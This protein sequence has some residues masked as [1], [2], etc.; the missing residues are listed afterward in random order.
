MGTQPARPTT[1]QEEGHNNMIRPILGVLTGFAVTVGLSVFNRAGR[2]KVTLHEPSYHLRNQ[3]KDTR[4]EKQGMSDALEGLAPQL[5]RSVSYMRGWYK[6]AEEVFAAC[7]NEAGE[8]ESKQAYDEGYGDGYHG[9][10]QTQTGTDYTTG[11]TD[12]ARSR[13]LHNDPEYKRGLED[14]ELNVVAEGDQ[15][16]K[17]RLGHCA[18][19]AAKVFEPA[20][21]QTTPQQSPLYGP[22]TDNYYYQIG[23]THGSRG[24]GKSSKYVAMDQYHLGY[25]KGRED[26]ETTQLAPEPTKP[27]TVPPEEHQTVPKRLHYRLGREDAL[28]GF[29]NNPNYADSVEYNTGYADGCKQVKEPEPQPACTPRPPMWFVGFFHAAMGMSAPNPTIARNTD[30]A[31][32]YT[33]QRRLNSPAYTLDYHFG[34]EHGVLGMFDPALAGKGEQYHLGHTKGL[35]IAGYAVYPELPKSTP[36]PIPQNT[37]GAEVFAIGLKDGCLSIDNPEWS[38]SKLYQQ[39]YGAGMAVARLRESINSPY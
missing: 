33:E 38:K 13:E 6:G 8:V 4:R 10:L 3:R 5:R 14:A 26:W 25:K 11:Y 35:E 21:D 22:D 30:F 12:G 17:Y 18:G 24:R 37:P 7:A 32:G 15:G 29:Q 20:Q 39:G 34:L 2:P 36:M 1:Q 31:T 28:S 16:E 9:F 23:F 27:V 19:M